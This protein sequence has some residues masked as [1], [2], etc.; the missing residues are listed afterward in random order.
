M[1]VVKITTVRC[2][3]ANDFQNGRLSNWPL[4]SAREQRPPRRFSLFIYK[5]S[6]YSISVI[7]VIRSVINRILLGRFE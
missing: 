4:D 3:T 1:E 7:F 2:T 5:K 6:A